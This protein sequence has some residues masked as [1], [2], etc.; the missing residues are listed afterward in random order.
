MTKRIIAFAAFVFF[1]V[2]LISSVLAATGDCN[3][4]VSLLNQD[5]IHAVPGEYVKVVFQ[6]EGV[7]NQN[8]GIVNFELVPDYPFS[9]DPNVQ[10][11]KTITSGTHTSSYNSQ[12]TIPFTLRVDSSA[13]DDNYKLKVRYSSSKSGDTIIEKDFEISVE[14]IKS[15][16]DVFVDDYNAATKTITFGILNIGKNDVEALTVELPKQTVIDVK[17]N[18]KAIVG[19]LDANQDTT[20]SYEATPSAGD[21]K[22]VVNYNDN[23][24]ERRSV[25]KIVT[26]DPSYFENRARD[27]KTKSAWSY[28][29][30]VI[31]VVLVAWWAKRK[32][33]PKKKDNK[34]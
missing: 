14:D 28:A 3:L 13:L 18:N 16:F 17:G 25:E 26:Y 32:F 8:C 21:I 27:V 31:L 7:D 12:A 23:N 33:F 30:P 29:I 20:F 15:D 34:H 22:L 4:D 24:G 19:T 2:F 6:V 1:S 10:T 9:L 11:T 5:P